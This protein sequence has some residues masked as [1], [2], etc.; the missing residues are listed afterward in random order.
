MLEALI[1]HSTLVYI[2]PENSMTYLCRAYG[3]FRIQW[4]QDTNGMP[5][6]DGY[7][8]RCFAVKVDEDGEVRK[9][10]GSE[11]S[12]NWLLGYE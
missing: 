4:I 6:E 7:P 12:I 8:I 10:L 2:G 3:E 9:I 1:K 5:D 11:F